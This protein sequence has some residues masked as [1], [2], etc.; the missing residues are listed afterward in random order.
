[1]VAMMSWNLG[2]WELGLLGDI[3]RPPFQLL[4]ISILALTVEGFAFRV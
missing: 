3:S 2:P 1:M 4:G